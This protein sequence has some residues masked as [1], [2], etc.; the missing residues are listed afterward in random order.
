[1]A[2]G[3]QSLFGDRSLHELTKPIYKAVGISMAFTGDLKHRDGS[4]AWTHDEYDEAMAAVAELVWRSKVADG[5]L[6]EGLIRA[7]VQLSEAHD[8]RAKDATFWTPAEDAAL[9]LIR[10]ELQR[11]ERRA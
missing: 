9:S 5:S 1:M 4:D 11:I 7:A 3:T 6:F 2:E 8:R 10:T